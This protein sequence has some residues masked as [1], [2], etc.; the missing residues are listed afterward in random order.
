MRS[1]IRI[2]LLIGFVVVLCC[3]GAETRFASA[4]DKA[5]SSPDS[6]PSLKPCGS[7]NPPPCIEKPPVV[8]RKVDP[9]YTAEARNHNLEGIV[10]LWTIVGT[11]GR[12]HDIRVMKV[13]GCGLDEEAIKALKRWT[14]KP[15]TS[16]GKPVPATAKIQMEF[17]LR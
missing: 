13:L 6:S 11:D 4:Q 10:L 16:E 1:P 14:F 2:V 5:I 9:E 15:A 8:T 3:L 7:K 17:R 12:A